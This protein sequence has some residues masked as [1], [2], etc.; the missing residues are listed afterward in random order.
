MTFITLV[1]AT[2]VGQYPTLFVLRTAISDEAKQCGAKISGEIGILPE[3]TQSANAV[4]LPV[5][6]DFSFNGLETSNHGEDRHFTPLPEGY[7]LSDG[8]PEL[9][10]NDAD[11]L[12]GEENKTTTTDTDTPHKIIG[13]VGEGKY[14]SGV[15]MPADPA[16]F[17]LGEPLIAAYLRVEDDGVLVITIEGRT[18]RFKLI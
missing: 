3:A 15:S 17:P 7:D 18:G 14:G 13:S 4:K 12:L 8:V 10:G 5:E 9:L 16:V 2:I 6:E 11:H 1:V